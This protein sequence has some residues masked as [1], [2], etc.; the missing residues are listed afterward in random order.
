MARR[1][2]VRTNTA[3]R[4]P[5]AARNAGTNELVLSLANPWLHAGCI[6]DGSKH[7]GCY[8]TREVITLDPGVGGSACSLVIT[9]VPYSSV[10][11]NTGSGEAAWQLPNIGTYLP[12]SAYNVMNGMYAKYRLVSMGIKVRYTGSNFNNEGQFV[13]AQLPGNI[14]PNV[15]HNKTMGEIPTVT[16]SFHLSDN[17]NTKSYT[18]RPEDQE[19][20]TFRPLSDGITNLSTPS[21]IP[22]L[23][24]GAS[25]LDESASYLIE[26]V[27]NYEGEF[28]LGT[29][30]MGGQRD[31]APVAQVGWY[32]RSMNA[33]RNTAQFATEVGVNIAMGGVAGTLG[34]IRAANQP[35][36]LPRP[37]N[38]PM[39]GWQ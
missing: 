22:W 32:E 6:P 21:N 31:I 29:I 5:R 13:L 8:S 7:K 20:Y 26:V 30:A 25:G 39:L 2:P 1:Q 9:G 11:M 27:R 3:R 23:F 12:N 18:W 10:Y 17:R 37:N 15:L 35:L 19:D 28:K 34:A 16:N 4:R 38:L 24:F 33:L 14:V 36:A